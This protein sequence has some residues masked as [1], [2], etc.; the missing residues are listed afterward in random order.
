MAAILSRGGCVNARN[1]DSRQ[2]WWWRN[3]ETAALI[4]LLAV[5]ESEPDRTKVKELEFDC[6][7]LPTLGVFATHE[8]SFH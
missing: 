3:K 1:N 4:N 6:G 5:T 8:A 7:V 2:I